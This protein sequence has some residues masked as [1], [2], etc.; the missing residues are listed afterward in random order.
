MSH[1]TAAL[2]VVLLPVR[3]RPSAVVAR[4]SIVRQEY[5]GLQAEFLS[6]MAALLD[7]FVSVE[8]EPT[9]PRFQIYNDG[10]GL[11]IEYPWHQGQ[12]EESGV[13]GLMSRGGSALATA[14]SQMVPQTRLGMDLMVAG[15]VVCASLI[16][17]AAGGPLSIGGVISSAVQHSFLAGVF[18]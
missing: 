13:A 17:I 14:M 11:V 9:C 6:S 18:C 16:G 3:D 7:S 2:L 4:G 10:T 1:A 8:S 15:G 12:S 5:N